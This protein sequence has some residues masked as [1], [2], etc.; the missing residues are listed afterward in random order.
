MDLAFLFRELVLDW[1]MLETSL[2]AVARIKDFRET[3]PLEV[4]PD[5]SSRVLENWPST[6]VIKLEN[7]TAKYP[8]DSEPVLADINLEIGC[9]EKIGICGHSGSGKSSLLSLLFGL[10]EPEEGRILIDE[11]DICTIPPN[12]CRS[13]L[14]SLSQDPFF[15]PGTVR[16]NLAPYNS[17]YISDQRMVEVMRQ[18]GL[19]DRFDAVGSAKADGQGQGLD[20]E[21]N[22]ESSLSGGE[23]QLFCLARAILR[24]SRI[25][26]LDEATSR[27]VP[28]PQ[29]SC[30]MIVTS[31]TSIRYMHTE[32]HC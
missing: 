10:L 7:V 32:P 29:K 30:H 16:F 17:H 28:T 13:K 5:M 24:K 25:L 27:F 20:A 3:T 1:T 31:H 9:G 26:A 23:K 12:F 4:E 11:T 18:V 22:A 19:W 6:G 14:N 15:L 2:G 8:E 21:L